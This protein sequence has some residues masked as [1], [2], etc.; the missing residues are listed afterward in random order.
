MSNVA[1]CVPLVVLLGLA[2]LQS[3][4]QTTELKDLVGLLVKKERV[5]FNFDSAFLRQG[6][7][8]IPFLIEAIDTKEKG[9][10][11]Y[12]DINSSTIYLGLSTNNY[13]GIRAAYMIEYII[14]NSCETLQKNGSEQLYKKG[15]IVKVENEQPVMEPLTYQDMVKLK[16]IYSEWWKK[17]RG[18]TLNELKEEWRIVKPLGDKKYTWI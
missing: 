2:C 7:D 17:N 10:V 12:Q 14:A 8:A 18:K 16:K 6:K 5:D 9:F 4:A 3:K 13:V 15:T 11:G 1:F